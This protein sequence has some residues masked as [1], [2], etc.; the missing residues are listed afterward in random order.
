MQLVI[1]YSDILFLYICTLTQ[2]LQ[3]AA[4]ITCVHPF[5]AFMAEIGKKLK[6]MFLKPSMPALHHAT[7]FTIAASPVSGSV[8]ELHNSAGS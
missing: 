5:S 3:I 7:L 6:D 4:R 8:V 1:R 2:E